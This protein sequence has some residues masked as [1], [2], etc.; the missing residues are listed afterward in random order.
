MMTHIDQSFLLGAEMRSFTVHH[1]ANIDPRVIVKPEG[2]QLWAR[3]GA[4]SD[5]RNS[6]G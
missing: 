6:R 1:R 5:I 4:P 2:V 3:L